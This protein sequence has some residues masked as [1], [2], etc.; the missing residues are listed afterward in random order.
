MR[1]GRI[2]Y[3]HF[4]EGQYDGS[5]RV[6]QQFLAEAGRTTVTDEAGAG[7]TGVEAAA[8][9]NDVRSPETYVG[10]DR[11]ENFASPGGPFQDMPP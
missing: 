8:D 5:E 7:A 11:A 4:G 1:K 10:Y 3:H 2:R 9:N 6:I